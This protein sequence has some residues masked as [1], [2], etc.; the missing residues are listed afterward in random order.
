MRSLFAVDFT[1]SLN[2]SDIRGVAEYTGAV[3][4][5]IRYRPFRCTESEALDNHEKTLTVMEDLESRES[6]SFQDCILI[7]PLFSRHVAHLDEIE[8][9]V[10]V[11][12][13]GFA[14]FRYNHS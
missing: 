7:W 4:L 1:S 6:A 13:E 10:A 14:D 3:P 5:E 12:A 9:W 8:T 2:H 11:P